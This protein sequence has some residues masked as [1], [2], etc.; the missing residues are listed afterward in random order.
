MLDSKTP[1]PSSSENNLHQTKKSREPPTQRSALHP[2]S[3]VNAHSPGRLPWA[4]S[5][6]EPAP[7]LSILELLLLPLLASFSQS[8]FHYTPP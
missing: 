2:T 7:P 4:P 8:A 3:G 5:Q 1:C 6:A